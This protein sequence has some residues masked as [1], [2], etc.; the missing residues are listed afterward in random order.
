MKFGAYRFKSFSSVDDIEKSLSKH[1]KQ[2]RIA[3]VGKV[4]LR[5]G[6]YEYDEKYDKMYILDGEFMEAHI[7]KTGAKYKG[8]WHDHK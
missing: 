1:E 7:L 3:V 5:L 6:E 2:V 4:I 8:Q